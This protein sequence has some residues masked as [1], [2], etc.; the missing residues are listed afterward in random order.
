MSE[1]KLHRT[2]SQQLTRARPTSV[3]QSEDKLEKAK[4]KHALGKINVLAE[5]SLSVN[6]EERI[7]SIHRFF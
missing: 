1:Q 4:L 6:E 2:S 3:H 5:G 7:S